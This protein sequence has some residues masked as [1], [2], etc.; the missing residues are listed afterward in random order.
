MARQKTYER[1]EVL[2]RAMNAFWDNGFYSTST[3]ELA[4]AMGINVATMYT[5]FGS[6]EGLY[7]AALEQYEREVV[8][9]F[10]G[11]LEAPDASI[12]TVRATLRQF[13]AMAA[14]V[15][16]APGCLVTNA[17]VERAPDAAASHDVMARYVARISAAIR[18]ALANSA[19]EAAADPGAVAR[20]SDHLV[21]VLLGLFVMTRAQVESA[22]LDNVAESAVE[23]LDTF[24]ATQLGLAAPG[25]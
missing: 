14:Q 2:T 12:E 10:F 8:G 17:A 16:V 5:E 4:G 3:R 9:A 21:A 18:R 24:F 23:Q 11:P 19:G 25:P 7:A 22:V 6:K 15:A 20:M 1:D 13:P